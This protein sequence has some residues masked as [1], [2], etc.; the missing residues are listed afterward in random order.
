MSIRLKFSGPRWWTNIHC[1]LHLSRQHV[2]LLYRPCQILVSSIHHKHEDDESAIRQMR[3]KF[4]NQDTGKTS[5]IAQLTDSCFR[6]H[7]LVSVKIV[8]TLCWLLALPMLVCKI[9][10]VKIIHNIVRMRRWA[11]SKKKTVSS[12][13]VPARFV[14]DCRSLGSR[15]AGKTWVLLLWSARPHKISMPQEKWQNTNLQL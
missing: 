3:K 15:V 9:W 7:K 11:R 2:R 12:V 4:R 13:S 14:W 5:S 8:G 6:C 10:W 1:K